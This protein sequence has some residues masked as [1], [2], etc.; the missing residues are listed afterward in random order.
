MILKKLNVKNLKKGCSFGER[1]SKWDGSSFENQYL[2][3]KIQVLKNW[4]STNFDT[5]KNV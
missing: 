4:D 5:T 2:L 1:T 3:K